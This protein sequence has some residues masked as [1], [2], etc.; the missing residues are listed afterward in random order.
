MLTSLTMTPFS[1]SF[2][3]SCWKKPFGFYVGFIFMFT[4][5]VIVY[6]S[7]WPCLGD[8]FCGSQSVI[9]WKHI[10]RLLLKGDL[11]AKMWDDSEGSVCTIGNDNY[12]FG[13]FGTLY[14]SHLK[15][16]YYTILWL[17]ED[18]NPHWSK[19]K[20]EAH[21]LRYTPKNCCFFF[22]T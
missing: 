3:R 15:D 13:A 12:Y 10:S 1:F 18:A 16:T 22:R 6:H 19:A 8:H 14:Q 2:S 5:L 17:H 9:F 4:Q 7:D 20:S 11:L 21:S